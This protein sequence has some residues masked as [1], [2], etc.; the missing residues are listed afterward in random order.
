MSRSVL[1]FIVLLVILAVGGGIVWWMVTNPSENSNTNNA[2]VANT[3]TEVNANA[4]PNIDVQAG[5]VDVGRE[6]LLTSANFRASSASLLSEFDGLSAAEDK[7]YLVVY[8]M[9]TP[10]EGS[11]ENV[12]NLND[13]NV[14]VSSGDT[15]YT[16][17]AIG[18]TQ[19][20]TDGEELGYLRFEVPVDASGFVLTILDGD[21][22]Q[23][24]DLG[25]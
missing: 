3:N 18:T 22:E 24:I 20:E 15:S 19:S 13:Q 23:T 16:L 25:F 2:V 11:S 6:A 17:Q 7:S 8:Y 4:A 1:I 14:S 10:Y 5:A 9:L 21:I 12:P